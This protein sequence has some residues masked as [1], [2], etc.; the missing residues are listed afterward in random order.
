MQ[1]QNF[2]HDRLDWEPGVL[3]HEPLEARGQ[4]VILQNLLGQVGVKDSPRAGGRHL[5]G[6]GQPLGH[7]FGDRSAAGAYL[8]RDGDR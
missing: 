3:G 8:A 1:P 5:F 4:L 7:Q 6:G 2:F